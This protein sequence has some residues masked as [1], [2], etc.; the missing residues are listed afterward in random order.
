VAQHGVAADVFVNPAQ[1]EGRNLV[2]H[3]DCEDA[4]AHGARRADTMTHGTELD[5]ISSFSFGDSSW[6]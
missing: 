4:P 6:Q 3:L 2:V 5:T 1:V